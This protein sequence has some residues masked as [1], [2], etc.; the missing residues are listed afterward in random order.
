MKLRET[1]QHSH[2]TEMH[3]TD[4]ETEIDDSKK[5]FHV[6]MLLRNNL[7]LCG[8]IQQ[9][10]EQYIALYYRAMRCAKSLV[11]MSTGMSDKSSICASGVV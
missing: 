11:I 1:E 3:R 9:T 6:Y 7:A 5:S 10:T 8:T 2:E 4:H